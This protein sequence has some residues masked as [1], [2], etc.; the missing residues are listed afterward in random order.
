MSKQ[1]SKGVR[2]LGIEEA[3]DGKHKYKA[4]F[5]V[6]GEAG[7]TVAGG[8]QSVHHKSV[9][10]GAVGYEDYTQ[11]H[12]DARRDSYL[13]RHGAQEDFENPTSAGALSR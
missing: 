8:G 10:F 2:L 6:A 7:S 1:Q 11:H 4:N 13:K 12:D 9:A 3:S 5:E